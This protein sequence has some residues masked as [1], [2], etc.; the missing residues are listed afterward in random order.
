MQPSAP[1][2][3][4]LDFWF[5]ELNDG[6]SDQQTRQRWFQVDGDFDQQCGAFAGLLDTVTTGDLDSWLHSG[7]GCLAY[8]LLCDQLPRNIYRGSKQAF[9]WDQLALQAA[10][11]GIDLGLDRSLGWDER[12][13]FYMPFEHSERLLDQYTAVGLFASLRDESPPALREQTGN[14]LR[15][16]QQHR[17]IIQRFQRFPHR[18]Q[19]LE[20]TSTEAERA[21]IA[22]GDGFGQSG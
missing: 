12:S 11:S 19:V 13:F 1:F 8:I 20:R 18:N 21:F 22:R 16:A 6:L 5:G 10:T 3:P 17:D 14:N 15:F 7:S 9:A 4:L 2:Q